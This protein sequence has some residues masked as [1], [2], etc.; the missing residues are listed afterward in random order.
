MYRYIDIFN[1]NNIMDVYVLKNP[2]QFHKKKNVGNH[3]L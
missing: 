2:Q 1:I 3:D